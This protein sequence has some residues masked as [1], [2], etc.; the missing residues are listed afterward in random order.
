MNLYGNREGVNQNSPVVKILLFFKLIQ[1]YIMVSLSTYTHS[2]HF[3]KLKPFFI[4]FYRIMLY[5]QLQQPK[6][7]LFQ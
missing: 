6:R 3:K 5:Q 2:L 1:C 7:H 4:S